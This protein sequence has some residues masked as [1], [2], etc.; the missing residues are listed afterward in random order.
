MVREELH[1]ALPSTSNDNSHVLPSLES[2]RHDQM[3]LNWRPQ[4][5]TFNCETITPVGLV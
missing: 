4:Q 5:M 1:L 3:A 2:G